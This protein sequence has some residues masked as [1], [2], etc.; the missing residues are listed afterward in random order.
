MDG[1][2]SEEEPKLKPETNAILASRENSNSVLLG[3]L[4]GSQAKGSVRE[5]EKK[6]QKGRESANFP[7]ALLVSALLRMGRSKGL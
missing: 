1:L 7:L 4:T 3:D 2:L 5:G 6:A